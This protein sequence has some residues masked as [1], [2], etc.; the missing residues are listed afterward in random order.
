MPSLPDKF[1]K[2]YRFIDGLFSETSGTGTTGIYEYRRISAKSRTI[3]K[4]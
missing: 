1:I 2:N 3:H 4:Q